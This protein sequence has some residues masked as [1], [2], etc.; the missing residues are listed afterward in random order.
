[1]PNNLTDALKTASK[2][3]IQ[4]LEIKFKK[5]RELYHKMVQRQLLMKQ[6]ILSMIKK[7]LKKIY[8]SRKRKKHYC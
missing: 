6:K 1:M 3:T 8:I 4:K 5:S 2:R 7:Y